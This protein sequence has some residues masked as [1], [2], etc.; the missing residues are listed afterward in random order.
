MLFN[1]KHEITSRFEMPDHVLDN[2]ALE[3][4]EITIWVD[5]LDGTQGFI[6]G[7]LQ[8]VTVMIGVAVKGVPLF[9]VIH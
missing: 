6:R 8:S 2:D 9:G 3:I 4:D 7:E 5:P 1:P